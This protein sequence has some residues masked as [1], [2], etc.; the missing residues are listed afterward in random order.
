[1]G[2]NKENTVCLVRGKAV[3][4]LSRASMGPNGSNVDAINL[5]K[6]NALAAGCKESCDSESGR[7]RMQARNE[8]SGVFCLFRLKMGEFLEQVLLGQARL[9][10][11]FLTRGSRQSLAHLHAKSS[12]RASEICRRRLSEKRM[13]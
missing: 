7:E 2:A 6:M 13:S 9:V 11:R 3:F 1:M 10:S 5:C 12:C 8:K 4:F